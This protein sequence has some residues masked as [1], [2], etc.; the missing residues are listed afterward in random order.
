MSRKDSILRTVYP[1]CS[2]FSFSKENLS[3]VIVGQILVKISIATNKRF[4]YLGIS[5]FSMCSQF[6]ELV[7]RLPIFFLL[8]FFLRASRI[9]DLGLLVN[10]F[11][12]VTWAFYLLYYLHNI[13]VL[14][15]ST[16]Y[17]YIVFALSDLKG[18]LR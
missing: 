5:V 14:L 7:K 13:Y 4:L 9:C 2:V 8:G 16:I 12:M 1:D 11:S 17:F 15:K 10:I 6:R 18:D 3:L